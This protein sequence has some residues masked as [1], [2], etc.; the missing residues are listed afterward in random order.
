[1]RLVGPHV[2]SYDVAPMQPVQGWKRALYLALAYFFL[3]LALLGIVLPVMPATPFLLLA[4]W[5]LLRTSPALHQRL[6]ETRLFGP[7]L[8]DWDRY[9]GVRLH[10]K[11]TAIAMV[12]GGAALSLTFGNL[13]MVAR[14]ALVAFAVIGLVVVLRLPVIRE[15]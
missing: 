9:H 15:E 3:V 10:V 6:Y 7:F 5:F 4:S 2:A 11:V 14:Y 13:P 1:M 8:R 12:L